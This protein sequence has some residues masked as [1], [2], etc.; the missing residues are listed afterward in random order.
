LPEEIPADVKQRG[1]EAF[2]KGDY[3]AAVYLFNLVIN[4]PTN[5]KCIVV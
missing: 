5:L 2:A 3:N 4:A 1:N